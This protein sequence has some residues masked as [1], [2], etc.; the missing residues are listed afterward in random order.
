MQDI[1]TGSGFGSLPLKPS[2]LETLDQL[3][4]REM[5]A[6]QAAAL[7]DALA[8]KDL[9]A[10]AETGSGK[11]AVFALTLLANLNRRRFAVQALVL[12]PTRELA[13]QV[14]AEIRRIARGEENTKVIVLCGGVPLRGQSSS[15]EHGAHIIV[16]TPGRI[17]D[18]ME[19]GTLRLDAINTFVLDE[20][21]RMLDMGFIDA[22]IRIAEACPPDRQTLL[23]SATY[24]E[25]IERL[26]KRFLKRPLRVQAENKRPNEAIDE[27]SYEIRNEDRF[28]S[29]AAL[30]RAFHP[31]RALAFC[32]TRQSCRELTTFLRDRGLSALELNGDLEQWERDQV[33]AR[34][35]GKSVSVLVA[36]DVASRGL[37]IEK[38]E[39]VVN[40][41]IP[42]DP[43]IYTHRIGRTARAGET[44]LALSLFD[45][46]ELALVR[47]IEAYRDREIA[48]GDI[49]EIEETTDTPPPVP[50][51]IT[52]QILSGKKD[53]I[54]PGDILGALTGDAGFTTEQ[55]GKIKIAETWSY[56]AVERT[57][58]EEAARKLNE[59]KIKGRS[60]RVKVLGN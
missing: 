34:F 28:E 4:Y 53:K 44:G 3:G 17:L 51:M 18:H 19:R 57:I 40:V 59:G 50:S 39:A 14:A 54:R 42:A 10:Q 37:D 11:T 58:A 46:S 31:E 47:R 33:L 16:G 1:D 23:F 27:R 9:I 41:D 55:V 8:G 25:G 5:T 32:N 38:L 20:A 15:L 52:L 56:V 2:T 43:E 26:A 12:C 45:A 29:V 36:T 22:I 13:D 49:A 7:K 35:A 21:D 48:R 60:V 6:I 30:L 24:P